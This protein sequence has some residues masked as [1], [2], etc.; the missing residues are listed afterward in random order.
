MFHD[1]TRSHEVKKV[2]QEL[3]LSLKLAQEREH[4]NADRLTA[5]EESENRAASL[6]AGLRVVENERKSA[7]EQLCIL[8]CKL[9]L[10]LQSTPMTWAF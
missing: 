9:N 1:L 6:E 5:E 2:V 10:T 8:S 4:A 3:K 7:L